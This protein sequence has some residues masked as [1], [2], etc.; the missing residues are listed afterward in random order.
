MY[1]LNQYQNLNHQED[2]HGR[3]ETGIDNQYRNNKI[4]E[5]RKEIRK[6]RERNNKRNNK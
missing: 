5:I 2:H 4:L 3:L 6:L 1:L